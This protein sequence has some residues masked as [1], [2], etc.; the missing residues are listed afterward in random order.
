MPDH[1]TF[2]IIDGNHLVHRVWNTTSG[3]NLRTK[4][5]TPSGV[6][7]GFLSSFCNILRQFEPTATYVVWDHKSRY[8][9]RILKAYR[10]KLER[11]AGRN[12]ESPAAKILDETP[13]QYKESRYKNQTN[14]D[15]RIFQ[16]EML[17]QMNA[18]QEI[19]PC[20]GVRQLVIHEVEGDDLIGIIADTLS[21]EDSNKIVIVSSDQDLY[22]LISTNVSQYDPIKK[23]HF[24]LADFV[25]KYGIQP[26]KWV[27]VKALMGDDHDDIPGVPGIGEKT[28]V[29]LMAQYSGLM[30]LIDEAQKSPKST[31][32]SRIPTYKEQIRLSYELSYILSSVEQLDEDQRDVF[33]AQWNE[34]ASVDWDEIQRFV[35]AYE[36]KKVNIELRAVL[37]DNTLETELSN[38]ESL[39]K[40]FE[41]WGECTRCKLH[42]V[43]NKIVRYSG[44]ARARIMGLGEGPGPTEDFYGDPFL[45]NAGRYL[46][47]TLLASAGLDRSEIHVSNVVL[48]F[49]NEAGEIRAPEN[50]EIAACS[51]RLRAQIKLV[52]P[53]LVILLGDKAFKAIFPDSEKISA[54][55]GIPLQHAEYPGITFVPVFHPSYLMRLQQ[56]INGHSDVVKSLT[57]WKLIKQLADTL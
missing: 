47:K 5:G 43:R 40:M 3:Q 12:P 16:E 25:T 35:D 45:G 1:K 41:L 39:D 15:H 11:Q 56:G 7:H 27:E 57:D 10:E 23:K 55:R 8:R 22:Q 6:I 32:M 29:K 46:N 31:A 51:P 37:I 26:E 42:A 54:A 48:C 49:P 28:A 33:E 52:N 13:G 9:R 34:A 50:E 44:P 20:L 4:D 17:P 21:Q 14:E 38:A 53:K 30:D 36:L 2:V 24:T 19:L 18:I